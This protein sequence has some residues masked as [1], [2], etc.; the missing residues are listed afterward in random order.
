MSVEI[1]ATVFI[2]QELEAIL[3]LRDARNLASLLKSTKQL[4]ES[5]SDLM[6]LTDLGV[7]CAQGY[8]LG[9]PSAIPPAC[10]GPETVAH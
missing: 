3:D 2:T 10:L 1:S 6:V 9:K 8:F 4:M 7:S 5:K